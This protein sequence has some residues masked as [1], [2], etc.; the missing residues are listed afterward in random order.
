[1]TKSL[2]TFHKLNVEIYASLFI[3]GAGLQCTAWWW[4]QG[5]GAACRQN[6]RHLL[7][8]R[9]LPS[10]YCT[11]I[12]IHPL[13]AMQFTAIFTLLMA[14]KLTHVGRFVIWLFQ[15]FYFSASWTLLL[16]N[17]LGHW[18]VGPGVKSMKMHEEDFRLNGCRHF[19]LAA[20]IS[21]TCA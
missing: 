6:C 2:C 17:K 14:A 19:W 4:K 20:L 11:P 12:A 18:K 7:V 9:R 5:G 3:V 13:A 10:D 15:T 1:M 16:G 21:T 8:E